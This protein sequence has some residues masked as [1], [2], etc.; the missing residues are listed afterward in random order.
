MAQVL[1]AYGIPYLIRAALSLYSN[2]TAR[3]MSTEGLSDQFNLDHGVTK[4]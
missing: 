2:P 4:G 3:D 1:T